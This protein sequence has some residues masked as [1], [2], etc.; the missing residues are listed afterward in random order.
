MAPACPGC[1]AALAACCAPLLR[2]VRR[3]ARQRLLRALGLEREA[4]MHGQIV[5]IFRARQP[6]PDLVGGA[7][8]SSDISS[9]GGAG[10]SA[11]SAAVCRPDKID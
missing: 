1:A 8:L 9:P 4:E 6:D 7:A 11:A 10:L 3:G 2:R 5:E